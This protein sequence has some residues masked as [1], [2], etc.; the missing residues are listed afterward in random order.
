LLRTACRAMRKIFGAD[1]AVI[2]AAGDAAAEGDVDRRR[3]PELIA[4]IAPLAGPAPSRGSETSEPLVRAAIIAMPE[5][6]SALL[7]PMRSRGNLHGWTLLANRRD[8]SP[9]SDDDARLALAAA[10]QIRAEHESLLA[11]SA[12]LRS[13]RQN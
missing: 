12:E 13:S 3:L 9:F 6:S 1:Y 7:V 11:Q 8:G 4:R 10:S 5:T 2:A